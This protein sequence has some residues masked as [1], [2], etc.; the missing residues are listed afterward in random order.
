MT[1]PRSADQNLLCGILALQMDFVT[2]D[3]LIEAMHA[4]ALRKATPLADLLLER[5]WLSAEDRDLLARMVTRHIDR[6]GQSPTRSLAAV[7][8]G[9]EL[10]DSL[11]RV[12]D[13]DVQASLAP[14]TATPE[15]SQPDS[16]LTVPPPPAAWHGGGRF[17]KLRPHARGGLGEECVALDEELRREVALKEIQPQY[18]D[19][20]AS[21]ARFLRRAGITGQLEHPGVVPIYGLGAFPDGRPYYA[22]RFVRGE[23]LHEAIKRFHADD[24]D[25]RRAPGERA[26]ELR[27]LLGH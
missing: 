10:R 24:R 23:S 12:A 1:A 13:P 16:S 14:L 27:R 7:A 17:R 19:H 25:G 11:A 18:A 26:L 15:S 8:V 9:R 21:W 4:W 22:M 3:Q 5:G 6:H 20:R 2:K